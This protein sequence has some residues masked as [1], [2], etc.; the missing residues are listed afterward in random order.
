MLE[1]TSEK[2]PDSDANNNIPTDAVLDDLPHKQA[3]STGQLKS[4]VIV[5][6]EK[7]KNLVYWCPDKET[8]EKL[9]SSIRDDVAMIVTSLWQTSGVVARPSQSMGA[10]KD[11]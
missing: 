7:L 4:T 8:P 6:L 5:Q 3:G 2:F 9:L 1:T 10:T 11:T